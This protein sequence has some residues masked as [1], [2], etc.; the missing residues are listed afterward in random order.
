M[1]NYDVRD[2]ATA[3]VLP[4]I[5][6]AEL[7]AASMRTP[8]GATLAYLDADDVWQLV[9]VSDEGRMKRLGHEVKTVYVEER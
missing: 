5:A 3:R 1:L 6:S 2:Y 7:V 8:V 9:Q 4:G